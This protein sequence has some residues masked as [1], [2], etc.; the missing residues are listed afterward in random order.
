MGVSEESRQSEAGAPPTSEA[1]SGVLCIPFERSDA[2]DERNIYLGKLE[3]WLISAARK[4]GVA[5]A[6]IRGSYNS[7]LEVIAQIYDSIEMA[8]IVI[9]VVHEVNPN[10]F[11]ECGFAVGRGKPVLYVA[12]DEDT[13]PFDIAGVERV[14]YS[15]IDSASEEKLTSAIQACLGSARERAQL[16]EPLKEAVQ[17]FEQNSTAA[18]RLFSLSLHYVLSEVSNWLTSMT[19]QSF[20]VKGAASILDAGTHILKN[21]ASHGFATQYYSG[22]ASW[23]GFASKGSRDDY[24]VATREAVQRGRDIVR[25]YVLD[26]VSQLDDQAFRET[27]MADMSA[28][29]DA[30]YILASE[31]PHARARDFGIWDGEL[32]ADIEYFAGEGSSPSLQRCVYRCDRASLNEADR[33]RENILRFAKPC[34]DLPSER[35]LLAE[36]AFGLPA[37]WEHYCRATGGRKDDCADYHL[38]WQRLRLCGMVSTPGWHSGFYSEAVRSWAKAH[39]RRDSTDEPVRVLITG[40]ADYGML[41]WLVQSLPPAIRRHCEIHVLD[42]CRTPLES[43]LWLSFELERRMQPGLKMNVELHHEDILA[44]KRPAA[45]FDLIVS[46]AFLT[47]FPDDATKLAVMEE[48]LRLARSGGSILTTARVRAGVDDIKRSDRKDFV[49]KAIKRAHALG[50]DPEEIA[51]AATAYAEY[52]TSFPFPSAAAVRQFLNSFSARASFNDPAPT[53]ISDQE[54]VPAHYT[55]IEMRRR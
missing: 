34:P 48:W 11:Y 5:L 9:G 25:V 44:G 54:M 10:V 52:I 50:L 33:W 18:H 14:T 27:V 31:L 2:S 39:Q 45:T 42:I 53:L 41:Y 30:Q 24:F 36:S 16:A 21:L 8:D 19:S 22:Q 49:I 40:L 32:R 15:E 35:E 26:E 46:D 47:R 7:S 37:T 13:V 6:P 4:A 43:C 38:P 17:H 12:H 28:G 29:V 51:T 55:R 20:E 23:H 1:K 3:K